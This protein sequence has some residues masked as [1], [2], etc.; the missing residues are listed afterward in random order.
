MVITTSFATWFGAETVMGI[1]AKFIG[2][3]LREVIEDP[4][5]ASMCFSA[6]RAF[7]ATR[8]YK[9]HLLTIGDFIASALEF[10]SRSFARSSSSSAISVGWRLRSLHSVCFLCAL[11][12]KHFAASWYGDRTVLVLIYVM[13]GGMMA[14]AYTDFVQ[15]IVLVLGMSYIAWYASDLVGGADKV[16]AVASERDWY[17]IL[18]EPT[19][20]N[21]MFFIASAITMMLGSIPQQTCFNV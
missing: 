15:M 10:A 9:M 17:R 5:G 3:G 21:W 13:I 18:P 11:G 4:F 1:P 6:G 20:H 8:L 2:G 19:V 7:F 12:R 14:V 16:F